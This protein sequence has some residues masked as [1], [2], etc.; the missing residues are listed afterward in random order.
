MPG[1]GR[2][3]FFAD[4]AAGEA[5]EEASAADDDDAA[6]DDAPASAAAATGAFGFRNGLLAVESA[7]ATDLAR[8]QNAAI[9]C[10]A[11]V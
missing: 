5:V 9:A 2:R 3:V 4:G 6:E 10:I 11:M 8:V 7:Y 1:L